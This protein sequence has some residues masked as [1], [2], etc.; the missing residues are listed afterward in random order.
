MDTVA[1]PLDFTCVVVDD[2]SIMPNHYSLGLVIEPQG[3]ITDNIGLG[4]KKLRYFVNESLSNSLFINRASLFRECL[5]QSENNMVLLPCEPLDYYVGCILLRKF[6]TITQEYFDIT[7][8]NID[9]AIG[10]RV[11]YNIQDPT[12]CR[13]ELGNDWWDIDDASTGSKIT[14]SWEELNLIPYPNWKPTIIKGG[15][16]GHR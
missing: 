16:S 15:L 8:I 13:I 9:S 1:W 11:L 5:T 2:H 3:S 7:E 10:D 14:K 12:E 4:F 6:L